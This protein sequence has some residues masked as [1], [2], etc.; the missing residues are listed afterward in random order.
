MAGKRM[1]YIKEATV[2]SVAELSKHMKCARCGADPP[3]AVT[4]IRRG[5][6]VDD[7]IALPLIIEGVAPPPEG[8]GRLV[9][10]TLCAS[11]AAILGIPLDE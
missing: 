9:I 6:K 8:K 1:L 7:P 4:L 5:I 3:A 11:C 10:F 2:E